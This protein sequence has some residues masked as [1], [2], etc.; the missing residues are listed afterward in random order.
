MQ[1]DV[2][3]GYERERLTTTFEEDQITVEIKNLTAGGG[4]SVTLIGQ[5]EE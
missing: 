5:L 2:I 3:G 1:R 4:G